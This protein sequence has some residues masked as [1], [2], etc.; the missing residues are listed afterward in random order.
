MMTI[1]VLNIERGIHIYTYILH[2]NEE[3]N[4]FYVN[5][6]FFIFFGLFMCANITK[7]KVADKP[8]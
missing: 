1:F 2:I 3:R 8:T 6:F 5:A 4:I 7:T